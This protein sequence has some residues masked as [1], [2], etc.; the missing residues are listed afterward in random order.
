MRQF[1]P[2][3]VGNPGAATNLV[4]GNDG[5]LYGA[6]QVSGTSYGTI[7]GATPSSGSFTTI[8]ACGLA[9]GY[10]GLCQINAV[11]PSGLASGNVP[12]VIAAGGA[13]S[14]VAMLPVQ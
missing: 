2:Q 7:F 10:V 13:S 3:Y 14:A 12:V 5:D 4:V 6:T 8:Y 1:P 11:V 9:P